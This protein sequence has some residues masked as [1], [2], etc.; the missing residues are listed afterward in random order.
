MKVR[1]QVEFQVEAFV[2][3]LVPEPRRRVTQGI[4]ALAK[5]QRDL[6]IGA[7]NPSAL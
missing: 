3:S 6:K 2:K 5:N 1:V 7:E 4:K